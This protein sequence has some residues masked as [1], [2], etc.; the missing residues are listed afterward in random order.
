MILL[1]EIVLTIVAWRKGWRWKALR[2][3][4]VSAVVGL[5]LGI[6]LVSGGHTSMPDGAKIFGLLVDVVM[7][8]WLIV[9]I[10]TAKDLPPPGTPPRELMG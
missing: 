6:A 5:I 2:P 8:V 3:V 7:V 10:T 4:G 1:L 9:M